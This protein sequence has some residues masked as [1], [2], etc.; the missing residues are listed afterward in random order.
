MFRIGIMVYAEVEFKPTSRHGT[1]LSLQNVSIYMGCF[2][3]QMTPYLNSQCLLFHSSPNPGNLLKPY[4]QVLTIIDLAMFSNVIHYQIKGLCLK[5]NVTSE[6]AT[7][8]DPLYAYKLTFTWGSIRSPL[9][10][11]FC[12]IR[13]LTSCRIL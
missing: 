11:L 9:D 12:L 5:P 13:R 4:G 6:T 7:T 1:A 10:T 3:G 2:P 8:Y